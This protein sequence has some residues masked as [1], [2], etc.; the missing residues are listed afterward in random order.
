MENILSYISRSSHI[1]GSLKRQEPR[2]AEGVLF[3][4]SISRSDLMCSSRSTYRSCRSPCMPWSM[5]YT[6]LAPLS[7]A[8]LNTP[9]RLEL[10]TAVG[11][12]DCPTITLPL[13]SVIEIPPFKIVSAYIAALILIYSPM[14]RKCFGKCS[15][16]NYVNIFTLNGCS[17]LTPPDCTVR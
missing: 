17:H 14:E 13:T 8:V 12:P 3:K 5:P 1:S 15:S 4:S 9:A 7:L 11:P 10:I 6:F 2:Y 16:K